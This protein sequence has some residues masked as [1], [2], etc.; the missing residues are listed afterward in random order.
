MNANKQP[1]DAVEYCVHVHSLTD[2]LHCILSN[3]IIEMNFDSNNF[4]SYDHILL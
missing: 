1:S 2:Y 3:I 4:I